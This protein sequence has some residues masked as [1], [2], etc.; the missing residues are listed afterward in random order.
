MWFKDRDF[1]R[2]EAFFH[3]HEGSLDGESTDDD[4]VVEHSSI[5][6]KYLW[7]SPSQPYEV[8]GLQAICAQNFVRLKED[9]SLLFVLGCWN[10]DSIPNLCLKQKSVASD[11]SLAA[12][13][14][15]VSI[16]SLKD[17][18]PLDMTSLR[19]IGI[20]SRLLDIA[21]TQPAKKGGAE[22]PHLS[23]NQPP[24]YIRC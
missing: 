17:E 13:Y 16:L 1:G 5:S 6:S 10:N 7:M 19:G 8:K 14:F 9:T 20:L 24:L 18:L 4:S 15:S 12:P 21:E 2:G 11:M 23:R 3:L 22:A